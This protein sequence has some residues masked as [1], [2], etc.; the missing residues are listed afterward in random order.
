MIFPASGVQIQMWLL[1]RMFPE[2]S[3]YNIPALFRINGPF[4]VQAM[5]SAM[6]AV[7][8]RH[9]IFRT[10][11]REVDG[12]LMQ[13][14]HDEN[15]V[16]ADFRFIATSPTGDGTK[17]HPDLIDEEVARPFDLAAGPLLRARC[18]KV[19]AAEYLL[20]I[21]MH[22]SITD[23]RSKDLLAQE[24]EELYIAGSSGVQSP[25]SGAAYAYS[26]IGI[27]DREFAASSR[28]EKMLSYWREEIAGAETVID[29]V[30]DRP[31]P[32]VLTLQGNAK[33]LTLDTDLT[34]ALRQFSRAKETKVFLT[35]L[36]AY[37]VLLHHYSGKT[38]LTIG[39]PL[40]NRRPE[41]R[42][43]LLGCLMN[44]L[45][46]TVDMSD[47]PSFSSLLAQIRQRMLLAHRNQEIWYKTIVDDLAAPRDPGRNPLFQAGFTFEHPM[48]LLLDGLDIRPVKLHN[49]G[50]QLDFFAV[51]WEGA[52][53]IDGY[54]EYA[55]DLFEGS[56][57]DRYVASFTSILRGVLANPECAVSK[58]PVLADGERRQ[59][60]VEWNRVDSPSD[61]DLSLCQLFE[62]QV[63]RQPNAVAVTFQDRELSYAELNVRAN[64]LA[65]HL[66]SLG[67]EEGALVGIHME[68]SELLLVA[69]LGILKARYTYVP[70]DPHFPEN[71]LRYMVEVTAAPVILTNAATRNLLSPA[72]VREI[73]LDDVVELLRTLPATNPGSIHAP[74][75]LAYVIFTSGSTGKPKGVM[76]H[77]AA[78]TN[79]LLSMAREPGMQSGDTLL[80]V[81]SLS[82]DISVLELFLP[83]VVG[84][85]V[86][87]AGSE[88]VVD[89]NR[90]LSLVRDE[91][92]T[93][94][95]ATPTTWRL[96]I[97]AG[98]DASRKIKALC[99]GEAMPSELAKSLLQRSSEVWNM[100]GPTETT[101]WSACHRVS[102][103]DPT[104][105]IGRPI[106]DTQL[107]ILNQ[108]REPVPAGVTGELY[109][110]GAGLSSGYFKRDELTEAA[111]VPAPFPEARGKRIYRTGDLARHLPDG[112]IEDLGRIDHQ[113]KIRGYRIELGEIEKAL[114]ERP[115][116][117]QS[118]V[119]A[120]DREQGHTSLVAYLVPASD[121][122]FDA[123][124]IREK[125]AAALP[126]Y[127]IPAAFVRLD[128]MPLTPN[129]KIDRR[130]LPAP[131]FSR[132]LAGSEYVSPG[133]EMERKIAD[134]WQAVLKHDRVGLRDRFFEIGGDS[135]LA[136]QVT[137]S[138]N[139]VLGVGMSVVTLF[140][141]PTVETLAQHLSGTADEAGPLVS[142]LDRARLRRDRI[143][144]KKQRKR[145]S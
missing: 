134:V 36:T 103:S 105:L 35:L 30:A 73:C 40:S 117:R 16:E 135:L 87:I 83:M 24:L 113:V 3:A 33:F 25:A 9:G 32:S 136:V 128:S 8:R 98:W 41:E 50:A 130:S 42:K 21:V 37:A 48:N 142:A 93:M 14:V 86:V 88:D 57:V 104:V 84:G 54:F 139:D 26:E 144:R 123:V 76:V 68:R 91:A 53:R 80:A 55:T 70:L 72:G 129:G 19:N 46:I 17:T 77:Q 127:M 125:L 131:T 92:V 7:V 49:G 60:L 141:H 45:P 138:M 13:V 133:T 44:I 23:L 101:V 66:L 82:F 99:G 58:L 31:R 5:E 137:S 59:L 115:N 62:R 61:S 56:T 97:E 140:Q 118:V 20:L 34:E 145:P 122:G 112:R 74:D 22:H 124:G 38:R 102:A 79:F 90:L 75:D 95:Q 43:D 6:H 15:A 18:Y 100:Y 11:F 4:D 39:V 2:N 143:A 64:R 12:D 47:S 51:F 119:V 126:D 106:A 28:H 29:L 27:D 109:I 52:E 65:N 107:Y 63:E 116:V 108:D 114:E 121:D 69:L 96:L 1:N 71:R 111:F 89:G 120:V 110:G 132:E 81:T 10:T 85:R 67:L 78:V 94:L